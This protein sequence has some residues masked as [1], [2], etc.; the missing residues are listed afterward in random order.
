VLCLKESKRN[1]KWVEEHFEGIE[2]DAEGSDPEGDELEDGSDDGDVDVAVSI[3]GSWEAG[4]SRP[5]TS[6]RD[7][8]GRGEIG[9]VKTLLY[10]N[11]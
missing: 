3:P 6:N 9:S 1:K 8:N 10:W 7:A 4:S 5:V 11:L 2:S